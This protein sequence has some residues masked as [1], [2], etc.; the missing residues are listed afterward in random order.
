MP[1]GDGVSERIL[2]VNA[3]DF[4]RSPGVNRGVVRCHEE[5]IVTSASL[6]VRWPHAEEAA[7]YARQSSLGLGLH[8]DLGEWEYRAGVWEPWYE[9]LPE[10]SAETVAAEFERQLEVFERIVGRPPD[11]LDSHQHVH[12]DEPARGAA[13]ALGERLGVPVREANPEIAYSG[14][15]FGQDGKGRAVPEAI[16][17]EALVVAIEAL[18]PGITELACHPAAT[19]DHDSA[20]GE[21]RIK[22]VEVLCDPRV[23]AAIDR[24]GITLESFTGARRRAPSRPGI[25]PGTWSRSGR[26][27]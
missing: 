7:A 16:T 2:I 9:V 27:R 22:E 21:E 25:A 1:R 20:Y 24:C 13:L 23:R 26:R 14:V 17:V 12:R 4:G 6:M 18:P 5:G 19:S 10:E 3:D 8:L 11:H 15:F